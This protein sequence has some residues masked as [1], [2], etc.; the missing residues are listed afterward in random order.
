[1]PSEHPMD[2]SLERVVWFGVLVVFFI[3]LALFL[4]IPIVALWET[5]RLSSP[6]LFRWRTWTQFSLG[7]VLGFV[8]A[9]GLGCS[10]WKTVLIDEPWWIVAAAIAVLTPLCCAGMLFHRERTVGRK[11]GYER[12]R[13]QETPLVEA[14]VAAAPLAHGHSTRQE[15]RR[16]AAA[17]RRRRVAVA[18][19]VT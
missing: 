17:P 7:G 18:A 4:W 14:Q 15:L 11:W 5:I 9:V 19:S 1:M 3:L 8:A 13:T 10:L 6:R 2:L 12:G 16:P